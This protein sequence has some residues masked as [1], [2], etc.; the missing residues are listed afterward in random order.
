MPSRSAVFAI[1]V[2]CALLV[3]PVNGAT[4][5]LSPTRVELDAKHRADIV[6]LFNNGD[7][8]LRVQA[9]SVLW[10]MTDD[11]RWDMTP[12]DDLIVTP[13]LVEVAPGKSTQLRIG[14]MA[15]IAATEVSYRLL[16]DELPNP[17]GGNVVASRQVRVLT[18]VSLPVF[19]DAD[20]QVPT[21]VIRGANIERGV[22]V[23]HLGNDGTRRMDPQ[24]VTVAVTDHSGR[25]ILHSTAMA[26]YV[27]PGKTWPLRVDL[28]EPACKDV[29][30]VAVAWLAANKG[31]SFHS[32]IT[33]DAGACA[34][35][36][37]N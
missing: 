34:R 15:D 2:T 25:T 7:E 26:N 22:L 21:P 32:I 1:L 11:G 17:A 37:S 6:T 31:P 14:S 12:S 24:A 4:F 23:I 8:P 5:T 35:T 9:R 18:Q 29:A 27:L 33:S 28:P 16:L 3:G 36:Q 13:E 30:A 19:L 20:G 10:R